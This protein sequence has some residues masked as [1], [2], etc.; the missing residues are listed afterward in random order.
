MKKG[1]LFLFALSTMMGLFAQNQ[2]R[3]TTT[4]TTVAAS[5]PTKR[6]AVVD[7]NMLSIAKE[8]NKVVNEYRV[9]N[10]M[11]ALKMQKEL[12]DIAFDHSRR[13]AKGEIAFSHLDFHDRV[14]KIDKYANIPY[15]TAEN[16]Y[17]HAIAPSKLPAAALKGWY[18]SKGHKKNMDGAFLHTGIGVCRSASGEYFITQVF[19][20]KATF[21]LA[22]AGAKGID[23]LE[24]L[25]EDHTTGTISPKPVSE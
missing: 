22:G 9:S 5:A 14:N 2:Q 18:N 23:E 8:V 24:E 16:L 4:R 10:G 3:G 12:N 19:V 20:G 11:E 21:L 13:M 1:F 17:A 25:S 15:H 7:T 6:Y